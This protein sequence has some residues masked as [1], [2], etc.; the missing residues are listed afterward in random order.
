MERLRGTVSNL[1]HS[2]DVSGTRDAISTSHVAIFEID[3]RP[4]AY[5]GGASAILSDGDVVEVT[6]DDQGGVFAAY[7]YRNLTKRVTGSAGY[8][9]LLIIGGTF[10]VFGLMTIVNFPDTPAVLIGLVFIGIGV[11]LLR[12]SARVRSAIRMLE[13]HR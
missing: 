5:E 3:G 12:G 11:S 8:M 1:R 13:Q 2:I 4:V 7:A 6:G 10:P 9:N